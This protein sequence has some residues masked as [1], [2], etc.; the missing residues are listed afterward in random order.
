MRLANLFSVVSL[1]LVSGIASAQEVFRLYDGPAPGT[2]D[3][4]HEEKEY[5][6]PIFNNEVVTNVVNPT[7]TVFRPEASKANGTALI[8]APGGGFHALSIDSEGTDV[9][10]RMNEDGVTCFVLRYRLVPTGDDGVKEM[11][12]MISKPDV[13]RAAMAKVAPHSGADGLRAVE[14]V[15]EHAEEFGIDPKRI[16]FIGFSAGGNVTMQVAL[17]GEGNSRADFVAPIYAAHAGLEEMPLPKNA[18][19][20]FIL[21]ASDDQLGL[22]QDSIDIYQRWL[23]AKRPVELHMYARGGHGFGMKEQNLPSDAWADRF[24]EWLGQQGFLGE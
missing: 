5:F 2:E 6:S 24:T 8:I 16:G 19:P 4:T 11:V 18:P 3:W 23:D 20:A 10:R 15:R 17:L 13:I 22:A 12:Q 9:A 14:Y 1:L 21:A 7:I